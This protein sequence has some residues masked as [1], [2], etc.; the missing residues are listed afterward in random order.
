MNPK[1]N[2]GQWFILAAAI[3]WGT[4]GT[5]QAFAP[6]SAQ[7]ASIGAARLATGGVTL[8]L[9]AAARGVLRDGNPWPLLPTLVSAGSVAAYQLFFFSGVAK[10]GVAAGTLIAIGSAPVLTGGLG[11]LL[12]GEVPD[13]CWILATA[14]A[15]TGGGL[16][17]SAG[18]S[19]NLDP[20]GALLALGAGAAYAVYAVVS[21]G[22]LT[23][24]H[25]DAVAMVIF[26]LG[27]VFLLPLLLR[28]DLSWL[29]QPRGLVVTLHLGVFA[30]AAAYAL[31]SRG[32]MTTPAATAVTLSLAEPLTAGLLGVFLL[33]ERLSP[34]AIV[35][36][37]LLLGGLLLLSVFNTFC[38]RV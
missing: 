31:F 35:G 24:H 13:R 7:P 20:A 23:T 37:A 19:L 25:P 12:R 32:L 34:Q 14:L 1:A 17:V 36:A 33:G 26:G 22:L 28:T 21:K 9:F 8:L 18:S 15:I 4:T 3:L 10:T 27:A 2:N 16:L 38:K 6:A 5:S 29:T 11:F 30:T